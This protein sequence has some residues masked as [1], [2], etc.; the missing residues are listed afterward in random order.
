MILILTPPLKQPKLLLFGDL[1]PQNMLA[2]TIII[3]R[4]QLVS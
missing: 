1:F 3:S 4:Q 2:N